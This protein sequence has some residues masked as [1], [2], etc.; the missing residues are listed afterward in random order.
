MILEAT[1]PKATTYRPSPGY[2][3]MLQVRPDMLAFVRWR[4]NLLP[5][6]P[7]QL[8][9][10]GAISNYLS[11]LID[12]G[13][14]M[15]FPGANRIAPD[16]AMLTA[17][18]KFHA[19]PGL[20]DCSFFEYADLVAHYFNQYL[21]KHWLDSQA[22]FIGA[23]TFYSPKLDSKDILSDYMRQSGVDEYREQDADI[24]AYYRLRLSRGQVTPKVKRGK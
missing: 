19:A 8:P 11:D 6:Q 1:V 23:A 12:F 16:N 13:K 10:H 9:G 22:T 4:E 18:L 7:I 24:K 17:R 20:I 2:S 21:Y 15:Y 14:S 3:G 5:D